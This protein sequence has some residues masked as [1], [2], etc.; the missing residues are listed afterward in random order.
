MNFLRLDFVQKKNLYEHT[1]RAP[2][3]LQNFAK[4]K[5]LVL[6]KV[7]NGLVITI[8]C[9]PMNRL[10]AVPRR[11]TINALVEKWMKSS[12]LSKKNLSQNTLQKRTSSPKNDVVRAVTTS[13]NKIAPTNSSSSLTPKTRIAKEKDLS[14]LKKKKF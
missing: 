3:F 13:V 12:A 7:H 9:P 8:Y 5:E 6:S 10:Y 11:A 2:T 4:T 14:N 1:P